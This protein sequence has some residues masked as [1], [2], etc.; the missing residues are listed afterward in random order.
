MKTSSR[1][2]TETEASCTFSVKLAALTFS[3]SELFI[4]WDA[5]W[6]QF[7]RGSREHCCNHIAYIYMWWDPKERVRS[8]HGFLCP[9]QYFESWLNPLSVAVFHGQEDATKAVECWLLLSA[10]SQLDQ[11]EPFT[12]RCWLPLISAANMIYRQMLCCGAAFLVTC[13]SQPSLA[14]LQ[15]KMQQRAN[16]PFEQAALLMGGW[17]FRC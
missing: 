8:L 13:I 2:L 9:T 12:L 14:H 7:A 1:P 11:C 17:W 6:D 16:R 15:C 10:Q 3:Q 4:R 5:R